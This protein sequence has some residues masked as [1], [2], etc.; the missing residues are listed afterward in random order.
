MYQRSSTFVITAQT[1]AGML[2]VLYREGFP[3]DLAHTC[4][5]SLP[6]A[7]LRRLSQRTVPAFAQT[8]DKNTLDGLAKVGFKTNLGPHGAG[9]P[10][11]VLRAWWWIFQTLER[12]NISSTET[13]KSN[14][15]PRS[16]TSRRMVSDLLM[17][18]SCRQTL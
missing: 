14:M 12:A 4:N 8:N 11:P 13:S 1:A 16:S 15:V 17:V 2:S 9:I 10:P 3:I 18:P 7:V 6:S 5:T